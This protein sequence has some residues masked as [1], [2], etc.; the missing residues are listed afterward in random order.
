MTTDVMPAPTIIH[1]SQLN[2]FVKPKVFSITATGVEVHSATGK[3]LQ[4]IPFDSITRLWGY[5]G[6]S[7][8]DRKGDRFRIRYSRI[9]SNRTSPVYVSNT[10][11]LGAFGSNFTP[12]ASNQD[13]T[14]DMLMNEIIQQVARIHPQTRLYTGY[15]A[16]VLVSVINILIGLCFMSFPY[17]EFRLS[18]RLPSFNWLEFVVISTMMFCLGFGLTAISIVYSIA[19]WPKSTRVS[20]ARQD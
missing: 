4:R 18:A 8:Q 7:A 9:Y 13:E 10:A 3:L 1:R 19:Y 14:Y 12:A 17:F 16:V 15:R 20:A 11:D 5:D 2:V 6:L